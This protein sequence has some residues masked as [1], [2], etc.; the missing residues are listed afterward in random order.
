[1]AHVPRFGRYVLHRLRRNVVTRFHLTHP[2]TIPAKLIGET[3]GLLLAWK[4]RRK[5]RR[6]GVVAPR[7]LP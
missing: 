6:G 1:M 2:W 7:N 4:L 3:R 5:G